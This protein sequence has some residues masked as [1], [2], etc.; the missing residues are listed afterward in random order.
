MKVNG[1]QNFL[2]YVE[3]RAED[4][5]CFKNDNTCYSLV[6]CVEWFNF[7]PST[8]TCDRIENERFHPENVADQKSR[9]CSH[10]GVD[11]ARDAFYLFIYL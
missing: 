1:R 4:N 2:E 3:P 7:T 9:L 5:R 11:R 8:K 6:D 10:C